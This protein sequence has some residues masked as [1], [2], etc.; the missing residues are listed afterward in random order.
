MTRERLTPE[1]AM[2][3]APAAGASA[4]P[5][6]GGSGGERPS[7]F[8]RWGALLGDALFRLDRGRRVVARNNL[9]FAF[10]EWTPR[11]VEACTRRT[12]KNIGRTLAEIGGSMM[13]PRHDRQ[14]HGA[15]TGS[16]HLVQALNRGKGIILVSAH[17]G[18]WEI[19][20]Q[21]LAFR[22]E[23][24][25]GVVVRPFSPA[26][27]DQRLNRWRSRSGIRIIYKKNAFPAM[28]KT[29]RDGGI[30]ALMVDMSVRKQSVPVTF[31]GRRARASHAAALLAARAKVT[32][33]PL[34]SSRREDGRLIGEIGPP[35]PL[36]R[37]RDFKNDLKQN[38]QALTDIVE[39]AVRKRP[40]QYFWIQK[41]WKDYHPELYP[42]YRPRPGLFTD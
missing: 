41:R 13:R 1:A 8:A 30:I 42:G 25:V 27:L 16:E 37:T 23:K 4:A 7:R 40:D 34:F 2:R 29:V 24:P 22:L 17:L 5:A 18:N 20:L 35:V 38:T 39:A 9:S 10:P 33:L 14:H 28:L 21:D 6:D 32:I 12:F 36:V 31:F 19:G 11:Q 26:V 3:P 15:V